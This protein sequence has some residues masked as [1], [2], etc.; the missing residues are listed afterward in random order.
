MCKVYQNKATLERYH[1]SGKSS[2]VTN[3]PSAG[4]SNLVITNQN[5]ALSC[6]FTRE[7]TMP[8]VDYY[9]NLNNPSYILMAQGSVSSGG[10]L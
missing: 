3:N 4:I 1:N 5:G 7:K 6:S 2:S 9:T 10:A 8:G